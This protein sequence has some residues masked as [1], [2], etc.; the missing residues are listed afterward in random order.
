MKKKTI[1]CK[2][3]SIFWYTRNHNSFKYVKRIVHT[4][5]AQTI[6]KGRSLY[7]SVHLSSMDQHSPAISASMLRASNMRNC[8]ALKRSFSSLDRC[9]VIRKNW[10]K[11]EQ[12]Y[13]CILSTRGTLLVNF[14]IYIKIWT[15]KN[16]KIK[17][18]FQY[19]PTSISE[20][21]SHE[22]QKL[23]RL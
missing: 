20:C 21:N 10:R 15:K 7:D 6:C 23:N 18:Y 12:D 2:T 1:N 17:K 16:K 14:T 13:G 19:V 11:S 22:K 5:L 4:M 8:I 3:I 9:Y